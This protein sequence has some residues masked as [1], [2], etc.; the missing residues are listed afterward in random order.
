VVNFYARL[1][2]RY[3]FFTCECIDDFRYSGLQTSFRMAK[4]DGSKG[5]VNT[6]VT[7]VKYTPEFV[8]ERV[9]FDFQKARKEFDAKQRANKNN[10]QQELFKK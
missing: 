10:S 7:I 2:V 6:D 4:L 1:L 3:P 8:T 5:I 9:T